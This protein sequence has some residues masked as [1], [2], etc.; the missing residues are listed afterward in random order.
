MRW[1][2]L[3]LLC[4]CVSAPT[5]EKQTTEAHAQVADLASR[6]ARDV[7]AEGAEP[8]T[9]EALVESTDV[10]RA[11]AGVPT[12]PLNVDEDL[13]PLA[14]LRAS[15]DRL[16]DLHDA[17]V[18][19]TTADLVAARERLEELEELA[20][21]RP[22]V[23]VVWYA[24]FGFIGVL[25]SL[26]TCYN[27]G[28]RYA[29][30]RSMTGLITGVGVGLATLVACTAWYFYGQTLIMWGVALAIVAFVALA[31]RYYVRTEA[32]ADLVNKV[33]GI[34]ISDATFKAAF[35]KLSDA[36]SAEVDKLKRGLNL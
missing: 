32:F 8:G 36:A 5:F 2:P 30:G 12:E 18:E 20:K 22:V 31:I 14:N 10:L 19:Q 35:P 23:R 26:V 3:L 29:I 28:V 16:R 7:Y 25:G 17:D 13:P 1:L 15:R 34:R 11:F 27:V 4:G 9:T 24:V 21:L 6:L 33:Q